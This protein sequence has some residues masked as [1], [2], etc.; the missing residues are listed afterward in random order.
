MVTIAPRRIAGFWHNIVALP[1]SRM[2]GTS[3]TSPPARTPA[4]DRFLPTNPDVADPGRQCPL[5]RLIGSN[6]DS[7]LR[8]ADDHQHS[9]H[10]SSTTRI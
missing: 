9:P 10:G 5:D 1:R 3:A 8:L 7:S 4:K 6:V 2:A